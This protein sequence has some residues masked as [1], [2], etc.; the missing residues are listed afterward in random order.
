M[1]H[2]LDDEPGKIFMR[3]TTGLWDRGQKEQERLLTPQFLK[4]Y[5]NYAKQRCSKI[6]LSE[7]ACDAIKEYYVELRNSSHER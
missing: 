2:A 3:N 1:D 5:I 4:K 6:D 7:D